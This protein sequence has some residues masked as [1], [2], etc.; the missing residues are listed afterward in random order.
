M[1]PITL[2][3]SRW[4]WNS[5]FWRILFLASSLVHRASLTCVNHKYCLSF[6]ACSA[7]L[8]IK[9]WVI[10]EANGPALVSGLW[11][12]NY[13][14]RDKAASLFRGIITVWSLLTARIPCSIMYQSKETQNSKER[15]VP[16]RERFALF[17]LLYAALCASC[18]WKR[19]IPFWW[20]VTS[21]FYSFV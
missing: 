15:P 3:C 5:I 13:A 8:H 17:H 19:T 14:V 16:K 10:V 20:K 1:L 2:S 9:E 6:P 21:Q 12:F 18:T 11:E 7:Q 4:L